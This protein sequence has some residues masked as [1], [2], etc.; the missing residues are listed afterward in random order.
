MFV[1]VTAE[2][3]PPWPSC[4]DWLRAQAGGCWAWLSRRAWQKLKSDRQLLQCSLR[5]RQ[6]PPTY[7]FGVPH[8]REHKPSCS[9]NEKWFLLIFLGVRIWQTL[10][11]LSSLQILTLILI[12]GDTFIPVFRWR[13][14]S[15]ERLSDWTKVT[16]PPHDRTE[17][18][19]RNSWGQCLCP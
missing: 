14:W 11:V 3:Q 4:R 7:V 13:H 9:G 6:M 16:Q 8:N 12:T 18:Q 15:T 1:K 17:I 19:S 10:N 2:N 5:L